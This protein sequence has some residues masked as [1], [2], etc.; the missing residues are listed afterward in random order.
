MGDE[1]KNR[2]EAADKD[3]RDKDNG[4]AST[5]RTG[6][7][8]SSPSDESSTEIKVE[9]KDPAESPATEEMTAEVEAAEK[10]DQGESPEAAAEQAEV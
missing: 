8:A 4:E 2:S 9:I 5:A 6:D 10:P 7:E 3:R 1:N